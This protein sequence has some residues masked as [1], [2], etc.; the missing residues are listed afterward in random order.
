MGCGRTDLKKSCVTRIS[1]TAPIELINGEER[2]NEM[3]QEKSE[4]PEDGDR[5]KEVFEGDGS[6]DQIAGKVRKCTKC[7][8]QSCKY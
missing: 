1:I 6:E 4:N 8:K 7:S 2:G 3:R 5:A